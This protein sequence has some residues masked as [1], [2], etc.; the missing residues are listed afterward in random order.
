[1][2][3]TIGLTLLIVAIAPIPFGDARA[4]QSSQT[5]GSAITVS[6]FTQRDRDGNGSP[7]LAVIDTAF[8]SP[9]D[10]VLIVDNGSDMAWSDNWV[11]GTDFNDDTWIFDVG[12]NGSAQLIIQF[13]IENGDHVAYLWD[14]ASGDGQVSYTIN[15]SGV[16]ITEPAS[17]RM[18]IEAHGNWTLR[19]GF[20]NPQI[21]WTL[22]G[23][24]GACTYLSARD[25]VGKYLPRN[26]TTD[27]VGA[28]DDR[29]GDGIPD[30]EYWVMTAQVPLSFGIA[31][32]DARENSG[33]HMWS[34]PSG[35]LFWPLLQGPTWTS[36]SRY[37]DQPPVVGVDWSNGVLME[38]SPYLDIRLRKATTST[39]I[40]LGTRILI[41]TA[42]F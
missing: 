40:L 5:T 7:D 36:A 29:D 35:F 33:K 21:S 39:T 9:G 12:S 14:D 34:K 42:Q 25:V 26:G 38:A 4:D 18:R 2:K 27:I 11:Q 31:R 17:W 37:F 19:N 13:K 23:W 8:A 10:Q 28:I 3:L 16:E 24:C 30:D 32:A 41:N 22:R 15:K 6:N 1:M 20:M